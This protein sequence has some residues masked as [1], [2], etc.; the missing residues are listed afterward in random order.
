MR[1]VAG[2][3]AQIAVVG[4]YQ[5]FGRTTRLN[6]RFVN[7]ETGEVLKALKVDRPSSDLLGLQDA[8]AARVR[9]ALPALR[10]RVRR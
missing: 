9:E 1:Q 10:T 5:R 2:Q 3:G 7:V 4:S 6:G 8:V